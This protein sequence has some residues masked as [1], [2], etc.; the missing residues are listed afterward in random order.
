MTTNFDT[1]AMQDPTGVAAVFAF[2][3]ANPPIAV[4]PV[5]LWATTN[6]M[7]FQLTTPAVAMPDGYLAAQA[8][9]VTQGTAWEVA[10]SNNW[11]WGGP[12][13]TN[14]RNV[15][16]NWHVTAPPPTGDIFFTAWDAVTVV[17]YDE[18][19]PTSVLLTLQW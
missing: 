7:R 8:A 11:N 12:I 18:I 16:I 17:D 14:I 4:A 10:V 13:A 9:V 19:S 2:T 6:Q 5:G 15:L 1:I 3:A